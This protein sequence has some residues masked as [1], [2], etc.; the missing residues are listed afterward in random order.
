MAAYYPE[1]PSVEE[2][3]DMKSFMTTFSKFYPCKDCAEHLRGRY[4]NDEVIRND[5]IKLTTQ[6]EG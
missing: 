3:E 2:Q 1:Q 4:D 6:D 5:V